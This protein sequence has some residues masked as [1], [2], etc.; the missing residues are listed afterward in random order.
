MPQPALALETANNIVSTTNPT[1]VLRN[2][3]LQS[4]AENFAI[5]RFI[6]S[7]LFESV[8]SGRPYRPTTS[9]AATQTESSLEHFRNT[10]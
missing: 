9:V 7:L 4:A 1:E 2:K 5:V 8:D 3:V 10:G 6:L